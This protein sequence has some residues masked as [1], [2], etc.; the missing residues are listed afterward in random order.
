MNKSRLISQL[1]SIRNQYGEKF[2]SQKLNLLNEL[3]REPVK[4]KKA[5]QSYHDTLLFLIAYPDNKFIYQ[6]ASQS[7]QHL[8]SYIRS[9]ENIKTS[10]FNSGITGTRL[11]AAFSFEMVKW[12]RKKDPKNIKLSSF[13]RYEACPTNRSGGQF[14]NTLPILNHFPIILV[15]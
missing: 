13:A 15:C 3:S 1:F 4:S 8:V 12:L 6:L 11:C 9:H 2:S 5:L 10:L 14:H 7:L